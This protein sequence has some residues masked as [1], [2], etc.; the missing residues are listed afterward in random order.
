MEKEARQ[1]GLGMFKSCDN[2]VDIANDDQ[3]EP[4]D[5]TTEI[6]WGDDGGKVILK[7]KRKGS[8][9]PPPNPGDIRGCSDFRTY[10]EALRWYE[11]FFPYYGDVAK[12]D[13]DGDGVPCSGLPHTQDSAKYR[14]KKPTTI[15]KITLGE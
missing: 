5:V 8:S 1:K 15:P 7:P 10:E 14:V 11:T 12:L 6:Q 9:T 3:F 4:L 13:R 2:E